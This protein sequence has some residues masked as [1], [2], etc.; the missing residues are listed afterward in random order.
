[1]V[2]LSHLHADHLEGLPGALRH[3][4]GRRRVGELSSPLR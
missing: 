2:F 1:V 4:A 3:R